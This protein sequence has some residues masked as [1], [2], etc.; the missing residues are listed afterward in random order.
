M[1]NYRRMS[2]CVRL[3]TIPVLCACALGGASS[4]GAQSDQGSGG[5]QPPAAAPNAVPATPSQAAVNDAQAS[6]TTPPGATNP[7]YQE[8]TPTTTTTAPTD[9]TPTTTTEPTGTG[10]TPD[11]SGQQ[12][13]GAGNAP[14][15]AAPSSGVRALA[16]TGLSLWL[17]AG[18]GSGL[19]ALGVALRLRTK[20]ADGARG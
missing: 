13:S 20:P 8:T 16:S 9:T 1:M 2:A 14:S 3:L 4:A 6:Q 19:C 17:V 12:P 10:T 15:A 7:E 18:L 11:T 5:L